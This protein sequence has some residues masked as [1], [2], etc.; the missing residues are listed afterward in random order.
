MKNR[1]QD[2]IKI[3]KNLLETKRRMLIQGIEFKKRILLLKK[4]VTQK[5]K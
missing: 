3:D 2:D 1:R 5:S 4:L